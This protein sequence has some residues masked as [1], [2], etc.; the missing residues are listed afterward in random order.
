MGN[1]SFSGVVLLV[2]VIPWENS[3]LLPGFGTLSRAIGVGAIVAGVLS[4]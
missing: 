4:I 1:L 2:F 3:I